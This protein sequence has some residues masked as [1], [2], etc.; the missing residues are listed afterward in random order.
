[1]GNGKLGKRE[2]YIIYICTVPGARRKR[3]KMPLPMSPGFL[4]LVCSVPVWLVG[5]EVGGCGNNLIGS[6]LAC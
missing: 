5:Q 2:N 1:M 4:A 6:S 3:N